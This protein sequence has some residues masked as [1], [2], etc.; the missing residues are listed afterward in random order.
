MDYLKGLVSVLVSKVQTT[1]EIEPHPT[2]INSYVAV[3]KRKE[4]VVGMNNGLL[5]KENHVSTDKVLKKPHLSLPNKDIEVL[6]LGD[7]ITNRLNQPEIGPHAI[8]RGYGGARISDLYDK[9]SHTRKKK[10]K[11]IFLAVGINDILKEQKPDVKMMINNLEKLIYLVNDKFNPDFINIVNLTPLA[12]YNKD[13][14]VSVDKFNKELQKIDENLSDLPDNL[15]LHFLDLHS[16]FKGKDCLT[17]DG[18]HPNESGAQTSVQSYRSCL[19]A[20]D[21]PCSS[22][23]ITNR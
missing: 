13:K 20:N 14:N 15:T 17:S 3:T 5:T 23:P 11:S 22:G 7:S 2:E 9:V 18:V 8:V 4:T 12:S 21:I 10:V 1:D 16:L 19:S 6:D